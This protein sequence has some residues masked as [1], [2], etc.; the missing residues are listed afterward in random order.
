V[1]TIAYTW[2]AGNRLTDAVDS[3]SGTISRNFDGLDRP[4]EEQTPQ[5]QIGYTYYAN[6][7]RQTMTVQGQP[8]VSYSYD[9]ANRLTQISQGSATV[10]FAYDTI[11]RRTT[12]TLANGIE[13]TY[14][15]DDASQLTSLSYQK[16]ST[17]IGNLTY[18]YDV[19]GRRT[20]MGGSLAQVN[21]PAAITSTTYDAAN[22]LTAWG[23]HALAYD[24]N[25]VLS[26][27]TDT[28]T[29]T[30][31][32]DERERLKQLK[33]GSATIASFQYDAF[34]RRAGKT[35]GSITT[36]FLNDGWQTVQEL[37]GSTV[38]ANLL[39]GLDIDELFRR[40]ESAT[41]S[42]FLVDAIGSVIALSD[43]AGSVQTS[44]AYEPYGQATS[45]GAASIN[46]YQYT[47]R[48]NDVAGLY[49]Y[50]NRYYN[51]GFSRF[52]NEDPLG[53]AGGQNVY[54]FVG[55]NPISYS[56]PYG[57][58]KFDKMFGLPKKFWNWCHRQ[59]KKPGDP[60][61]TKEE[62]E[63]LHKEWKAL[64]EPGPDSKGK[65]TGSVD[66]ELVDWLF[67]WW[68]FSAPAQ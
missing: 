3:A 34:N 9:N 5:G 12:L 4:I 64:G 20:S 41:T 65:Q 13:V 67:P 36:N 49:Y 57:L 10:G 17:T 62:A 46:A 60:D 15:Y 16:A 35:I 27:D 11:N 59:V 68:L 66:P 14:G 29:Q 58:S 21:L 37:S 39:T 31:T 7:L 2:D 6:G 32:W 54:A 63:E 38:T 42:D 25:G 52:T 33:Q 30:Y 56:D 23:T 48:D 45:T 22:R 19:A 61:L 8:S 51:P 47:G 28:V 43:A 50:R 24:D 18:S 55:G 1:S 44:Y 53:L 40:S 26:S